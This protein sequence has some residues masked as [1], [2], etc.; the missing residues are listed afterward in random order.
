MEGINKKY[1]LEIEVL[2]P[3]SIGAGQEKDWVRGVDFVVD[4][5]TLYKL[6]LKKMIANGIKVDDLTICFASKD[7]EMLKS[8][9]AGKLDEVSDFSM[10]FPAET[11]ND[12]KAFVKNQLGGN[13]V[14]TGSSLKGPFVRFCSNIWTANLKMAKKSSVH[15]P[16]VMSFC[17]SSRFQM[18]NL[19]RQSW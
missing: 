13:P 5:G 12:V 15:Q 10:S 8:K 17:V 16:M 9:L 19:T 1:N 3:L 4:K 14:L 7:E 18:R 2:T 11:D 6:N